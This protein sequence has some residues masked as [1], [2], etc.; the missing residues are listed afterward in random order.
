[1]AIMGGLCMGIDGDGLLFVPLP[2]C[3]IH[4]RGFAAHD[5]SKLPGPLMR[6]NFKGFQLFHPQRIRR[7]IDMRQETVAPFAFRFFHEVSIACAAARP[8]SQAP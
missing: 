3:D 4:I 2:A 5:V 7:N 8:D 6:C 1:M